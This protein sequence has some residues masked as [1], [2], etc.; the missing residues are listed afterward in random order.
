M[1][2]NERAA[3]LG[4]VRRLLGVPVGDV[5]RRTPLPGELAGPA[6]AGHYRRPHWWFV[7]GHPACPAG[8]SCGCPREVRGRPHAAPVHA[9]PTGLLRNPQH[10]SRVAERMG[11]QPGSRP[12]TAADGRRLAQLLHEITADEGT[13]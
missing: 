5:Y 8:E 9:G 4:E 12:L 7:Y 11:R 13:K 2:P 3:L 6:P 1:T 10:L